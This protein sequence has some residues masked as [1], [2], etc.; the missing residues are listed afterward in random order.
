MYTFYIRQHND[1]K[2]YYFR[3]LPKMS[4]IVYMNFIV[5]NKL[6]SLDL[7]EQTVKT[8]ELY[9]N[10]DVLYYLLELKANVIK[11][12]VILISIPL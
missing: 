8:D 7:P 11:F 5:F 12:L 1:L 4:F 3:S 2:T 6:T 10:A 9:K